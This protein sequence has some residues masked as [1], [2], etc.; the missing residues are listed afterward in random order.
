LAIRKKDRLR[1]RGELHEKIHRDSVSL[2]GTLGVAFAGRKTWQ[3]FS[4]LRQTISV[5]EFGRWVLKYADEFISADALRSLGSTFP[6]YDASRGWTSVFQSNGLGD[7]ANGE[8][9]LRLVGIHMDDP[10][11]KTGTADV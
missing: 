11:R 5:R 10:R 6:N 3:M 8:M 2:C 7:Y 1:E 9:G 4:F